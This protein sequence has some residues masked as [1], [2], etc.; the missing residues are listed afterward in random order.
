MQKGKRIAEFIPE[1]RNGGLEQGAG[2]AQ[3]LLIGP[4]GD[5]GDAAR[6]DGNTADAQRGTMV[7]Q[8]TMPASGEAK[9]R[10]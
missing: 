8:E 5:S 1:C 7:R 10:L 4:G 6:E 9:M 2:M 3:A